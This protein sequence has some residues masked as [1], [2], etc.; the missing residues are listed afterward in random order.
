ML[1]GQFLHCRV[2]SFYWRVSSSTTGSLPALEGQFLRYRASCFTPGSVPLLQGQ[3]LYWRVSS[4]TAG[5]APLLEGQFLYWRA[6]SFT[7]GSVP[8]LQGV[9]VA[10]PIRKFRH[11][12][13]LL[14]EPKWATH[15]YIC[16]YM[17]TC[18][19]ICI[20]VQTHMCIC[21]RSK[22]EAE[23]QARAEWENLTPV[24]ATAQLRELH[25]C[26]NIWHSGP[27]CGGLLIFVNLNC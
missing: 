2:S 25:K 20:Y 22:A 24:L 1:Q 3:L 6:S 19:H 18:T 17:C 5:S 16:I 7:T 8:S 13:W 10:C 12:G 21:E 27:A 9:L 14:L 15:T 26:S 4:F 23:S 11:F